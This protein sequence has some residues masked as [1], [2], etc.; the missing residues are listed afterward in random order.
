[1]A[2][3]RAGRWL[4]AALAALLAGSC[5]HLPALRVGTS[6]DYAPFSSEGQGFDVEVARRLATRLGA[7]LVWVPFRWSELE[8]GLRE[9]RFDV[10]MSGVTWRPERALV[11][12]MS[13]AVASGGPCVIGREPARRV[14]VNR[15]GALERWARA[16]FPDAQVVARD[17]NRSL[18]GLL[19]SGE[20]DAIA[21]DSFELGAFLAPGDL[22]RCEPPRDRKVYWV[23]PARAAQL[24]PAIDRFVRDEEVWLDAQR[25]RWLGGS[26][27]R[28]A[29][30]HAIDLVARRLALMP[31]LGAWKRA[32]GMPIA[33]PAREARVLERAGEAARIHGLDPE[34]VRSLFAVQI[35]LARALQERA[36]AQVE[37]LPLEPVRELALRLGDELVETLAA[38]AG[39]VQLDEARLAPLAE[40]LRPDEV[41]RLVAVLHDLIP[42]SALLDGWRARASELRGLSF[43]RRVPLHWITRDDLPEL[44]RGELADVIAAGY[45][46]EYRD[47]A[48]ALGLIPADLDLVELLVRLNRDQIAGLYSVRRREMFVLGGAAQPDV[49]IVIHELVHALQHQHFAGTLELMQGLRHHDDVVL[50]LGAAAEGDAMLVMLLHSTDS[51]ELPHSNA[52]ALRAGLRAELAA[53]AGLLAEVPRIV[54]MSLLFPYA[55]GFDLAER[56]Y[57]AEGRA[58]LDRLLRDP[59]LSSLR[60]RR[61]ELDRPVEFLRIPAARAARLAGPGCRA[62]HDN[63]VGVVGI[64]ALFADHGAP[65]AS[66]ALEASW[67][68]DRFLHLVCPQGAELVWITRWTT[69]RA[70]REF[71]AAYAKIAASAARVAPLAGVPRAVARGR[72]AIVTTPR[73]AGS[74]GILLEATEVRSYADLAAWRE[75]GCFPESPCPL[76]PGS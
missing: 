61:P 69:P 25:A 13:R 45:A 3:R 51:A 76:G 30:D 65:E 40:W 56:A 68:G 46:T 35:E 47:A 54:R 16:A 23:A 6:G 39:P 4:G 19:A 75:D 53:P 15:G 12:H 20:V 33:D 44:V 31:G 22:H 28:A 7:R 59:P 57:R 11:G 55:S 2:V 18:P 36:P 29:I 43:A 5:A 8:Q 32:A 27:P 14:G 73:L 1:M 60:V 48:A 41:E 67:S 37:P 26:A 63:V 52:D 34:R 17:D 71:A 42:G 9:G 66:A 58:G 64:E 62:G 24:G 70:A 49:P 50:A 38:L 21:T 10:A 72:S 74:L